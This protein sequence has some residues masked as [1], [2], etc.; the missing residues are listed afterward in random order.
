MFAVLAMSRSECLLS[1]GWYGVG[2]VVLHA[3]LSLSSLLAASINLVSAIFVQ[4][5]LR[6]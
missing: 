4:A 5:D 3:C 2:D 6:V 1:D